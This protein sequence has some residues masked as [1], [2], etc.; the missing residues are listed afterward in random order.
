[1]CPVQGL[2]SPAYLF[3]GIREWLLILSILTRLY[4]SVNL[5][6]PENNRLKV[7]WATDMSPTALFTSRD[8]MP[9]PG[10]AVTV[11][12]GCTRGGE[13]GWVPGGCWEGAIPGTTQHPPIY[14]YLVIFQASSPTYGPVKAILEVF[15][16][17]P[18]I[19]SRLT[20]EWTSD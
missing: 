7:S 2:D 18:E 6:N 17:F 12:Q 11:M 14:P 15:M 1:M 8:C 3:P 19:G 20:S 9:R 16:R 13:D 5:R 10:T 4:T